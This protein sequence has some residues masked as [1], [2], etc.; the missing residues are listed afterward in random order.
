V[1]VSVIL[2][3]CLLR[4]SV[5]KTPAFSMKGVKEKAGASMEIKE[6]KDLL[7]YTPHEDFVD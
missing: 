3:S 2:S 4:N 7:L 5:K 1:Y 6:I